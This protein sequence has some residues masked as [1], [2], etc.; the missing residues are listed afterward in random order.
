MGLPPSALAAHSVKML[1]QDI[2]SASWTKLSETYR[3]IIL[4]ADPST[5]QAPKG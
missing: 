3:R 1:S 4:G 5:T 2:I